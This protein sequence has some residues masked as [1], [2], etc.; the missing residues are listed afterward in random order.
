M[1]Q[2]HNTLIALLLVITFTHA[3]AELFPER[4]CCLSPEPNAEQVS[5][6]ETIVIKLKSDIH[7]ADIAI[8][9]S[10]LKRRIYIG[11]MILLEDN[12]TILYQTAEPFLSGET[13]Q[14]QI[15][16]IVDFTY[17]F[18]IRNVPEKPLHNHTEHQQETP[19]PELINQTQPR[20]V[21]TATTINGVAVPS[22]F[23][24]VTVSQ[25]RETA[26]G[27]IFFASTFGVLGNYIIIMENDGTPY[28]YRKYPGSSVIW[29]AS[30]GDFKRQSTGVLT[31]YIYQPEHY[32]VLDQNYREIRT[33]TCDGN[34]YRTNSHELVLLPNGHA[35]LICEQDS[36]VDMTGIGGFKFAKVTGTHLQE[37][38]ANNK[39][40]YTW[41]C[42]DHF[43]IT[44][45]YEDQTGWSIDYVHMNSIAVDYDSNLVI[46][47]RHLSEVTKINWQTK[48][49][50]WRLGGENDEFDLTDPFSYQ[51]HVRPVPGKPDHY[52]I[53]D[54]GNKRTPN[55]TRALE[56]KID[57][58]HKTAIK[59]WEYWIPYPTNRHRDIMG[60]IQRLPNGNTF[61]DWSTYPPSQ[62]CE[63]DSNNYMVYEYSYSDASCYRSKRFE[64]EGISLS[65]YLLLESYNT[66]IALIFNK[67]GDSN[68]DYYRIYGD[69]H[70]DAETFLTTSEE[71]IAF[72]NH[73]ENRTYWYFRVKAVY[74]NG[75]S[76]SDYSNEERIY[77]SFVEPGQNMIQ[78]GDFS[79]GTYSWSLQ[80]NNGA[81]ASGN[82]DDSG[83]YHIKINNGGTNLH[84]VRLLQTD[85]ELINEKSYLFEFDAYADGNRSIEAK[86]EKNGSPWHNYGEIDLT[87]LTTQK[88]HFSH[89]FK[90][91]YAN[92]LDAR[93]V[94]NCGQ[95]NDN[96]FLDNISFREVTTSEIQN[97]IHGPKRYAL[98][99]NYP[100]PFNPSTQISF[101]IPRNER[102]SII[103]Y[104]MLGRKVQTLLDA[105]KKPGQYRVTFDG[106]NLPSGIY[107]YKLET[108]SFSK[109]GKMVLMK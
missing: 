21:G 80:K 19:H 5:Q 93:V 25:Y 30:S 17:Q 100:N 91:Q 106:S 73:L 97:R 103:L 88:Q 43:K 53:Y 18:F 55:D 51:H 46:S 22:D 14:V 39:E 28:F 23:P 20:T 79:D 31:A 95:S 84:D 24:H 33:I 16:G 63:I 42:W 109:T 68:V 38:D 59:V 49:I 56:L 87:Y 40:V 101:T 35:L 6:N 74:Q 82:I 4:L 89:E 104:D 2:T 108:P 81:S 1:N 29:S 96:I 107:I 61:I 85:L 77:V 34:N 86:I 36:I 27:K 94:F 54:N 12:Q 41:H 15:T 3:Q 64:W 72:L 10:G 99:N 7:I 60:S 57:P 9:V 66:G 52:T 75:D 65:P 78:N 70:K 98:Y 83:Q 32:V 44:D 47:S 26:S 58:V 92:D 90:M 37:V 48:E 45:T 105:Q 67:F 76:T 62:T 50:M 8:E 11:D 13:V 102:V 69:T 71:T